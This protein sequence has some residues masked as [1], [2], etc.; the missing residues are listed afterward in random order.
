MCQ[1]NVT[2]EDVAVYFSREE[3][4]SLMRLRGTCDVMLE[5]F[6]L[7]SSLGCLC[8]IENEKAPFG[9]SVSLER[10]PQIRTPKPDPSVQKAHHCEVC[11]PIMEDILYLTDYQGTH[12][13]QKLNTCVTC[14]KQLC[15]TAN[16]HQH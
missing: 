5:N 10:V 6:A 9:Q 3:W 1:G 7:I 14:G 12:T 2:F 13:G 16:L 4:G 8:S 15:F 11:V